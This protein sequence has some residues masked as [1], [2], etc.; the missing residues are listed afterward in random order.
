MSKPGS[1]YFSIE[2]F[3]FS[4]VEPLDSANRVSLVSTSSPDNKYFHLVLRTSALGGL[5]TR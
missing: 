3:G 5:L 1:G 4:G 2:G